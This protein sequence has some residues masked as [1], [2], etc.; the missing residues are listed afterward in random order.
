MQ[1]TIFITGASSHLGKATVKLFQSKRCNVI[2]S[3]RNSENET[4]LT[5]PKKNFIVIKLD[6][7]DS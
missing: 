5:K 3:M 1:Q 4:E 7:T 6:V 2:A